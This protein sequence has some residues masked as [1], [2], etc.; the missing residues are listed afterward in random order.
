MSIKTIL[1]LFCL[2]SLYCKETKLEGTLLIPK[3][4]TFGFVGLELSSPVKITKIDFSH[5]SSEPKEYLLGI[6]Q[7]G[8][9]KTF[10]DAFPLYMIKEELEPN[11]LHSIQISC[12]KKFKYLRYMGPDEIHLFQNLKHMEICNLMKNQMKIIIINQQIFLF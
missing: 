6:F 1:M 3:K 12:S 5:S 9:D 10:F 11:K 8:N 4:E 7:G 2:Y